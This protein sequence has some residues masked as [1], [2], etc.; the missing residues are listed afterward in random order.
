M[1][2]WKNNYWWGGPLL[3]VLALAAVLL[4]VGVANASLVAFT[5]IYDVPGSGYTLDSNHTYYGFQHN[6]N[7]NGY[8]PSTDTLTSATITL[9]FYDND[10]DSFLFWTLDPEEVQ[11]KLDNAQQY[12]WEVDSGGTQITIAALSQLV[13]GI[14]NVDL[15][16]KSGDVRFDGSTLEVTADRDPPAPPASVPEPA[17]FILVGAGLIGLSLL[18]KIRL[19]DLK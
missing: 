15:Y 13:D 11:V 8:N 6:F 4:V 14:L 9:N 18:R 12:Q 5:D 7:D 10:L 19:G 16:W 17:T 3:S 1:Q 2:R